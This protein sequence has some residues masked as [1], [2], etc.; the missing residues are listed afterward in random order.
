LSSLHPVPPKL[1]IVNALATI[2]LPCSG[3]APIT[4]FS[5]SILLPGTL[6]DCTL[7]P[8]IL[9][10]FMPKKLINE[11]FCI[12][13][14]VKIVGRVF[15]RLVYPTRLVALSKGSSNETA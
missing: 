6:G 2:D 7:A 1:K 5:A 9:A 13:G 12:Y 10:P 4:G 8:S 3:V 14:D 11:Q 15:G